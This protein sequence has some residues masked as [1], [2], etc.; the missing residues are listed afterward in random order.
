MSVGQKDYIAPDVTLNAFQGSIVIRST[1]T[2]QDNANLVANPAHQSGSTG[3]FVGD[4]VVVG[5]GVTVEGPAAIGAK[6]GPATAIGA[7]AVIDGAIIATGAPMSAR[8]RGSAPGS[9]C[10]PAI[11]SCPGST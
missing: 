5:D 7:D 8:W 10:P 4:D 9:S 2:I 1:S 11:G 6:G 3:I